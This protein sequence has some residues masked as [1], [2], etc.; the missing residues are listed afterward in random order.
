LAD[1]ITK[2]HRSWNMSRIRSGD[3][4]PEKLVRTLLHRVGYRFRIRVNTLPGRPD[5]VLPKYRTAIFVHGCFWHRHAECRYA[6]TPKSRTNFWGEKFKATVE[7]DRKKSDELRSVG[8]RVI[9][10]WECELKK[11][12]QAVINKIREELKG[13]QDAP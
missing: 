9:V 13:E 10:V 8:W 11:N 2:E 6:Y 7:R 12:A 4:K 1:K 5:I 3:T